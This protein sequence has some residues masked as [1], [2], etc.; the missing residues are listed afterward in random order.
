MPA[1]EQRVLDVARSQ[2]GYTEPGWG[3]RP[4]TQLTKYGIW[5]AEW[6]GKPAYRDTYWCAMFASWVLASAGFAPQDAGRYGNCGP[7]VKWFKARGRWGNTPRPGAVVFFSW[8]GDQTPEHVGIVESVRA[9]GR[10]VTIEGNASIPGRKDGVYRMVRRAGILGYGYP[11][12]TQADPNEPR[13]GG[14]RPGYPTLYRGT[15]GPEDT[16]G[17][18]R[19]WVGQWYKTMAS[20]S[21]GYF[22]KITSNPRGAAEIKRL[23]IGDVTLAVTRDM[24]AQVLGSRLRWR[25]AID[26]PIWAIYPPVK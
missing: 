25:G 26:Q 3:D 14:A 13:P 8:N 24:A 15:G 7:W 20:H 6:A 2:L 18:Q 1:T 9:D 10:V 21:P 22:R 19:W 16:T 4:G 11:P 12:Y 17:N 23:E 5:Y